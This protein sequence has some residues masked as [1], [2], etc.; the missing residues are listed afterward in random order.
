MQEAIINDGIFRNNSYHQHDL[1]K[2][3]QLAGAI[4]A[5][6]I[7]G[8]EM[9]SEQWSTFAGMYAERGGKQINF[10]K[11]MVNEIKAANTS[12]AEKIIGQLQS[13]YSQKVQLLMGGSS[14]FPSQ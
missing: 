12:N 5:S 10:N 1:T 2:M 13:P 11:F 7:Q 3:K 14:E 9:S 8:Q 6:S 4:K